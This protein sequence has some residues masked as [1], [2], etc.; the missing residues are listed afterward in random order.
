MDDHRP[1]TQ[2]T[3]W[4]LRVTDRR[5]LLLFGDF[6]ISIIS[7]VIAIS[8][9]A[10]AEAEA[11]SF[12]EFVSARLE[13]WFFLLPVIWLILLVDS[14]DP[15]RSTNIKG[16]IQSI[17]GA[18][19]IGAVMYM[20]VYFTSSAS[21]PRRGVAIFLLSSAVLTLLWRYV[22]IG[23]FS[24]PR[25]LH[26]VLLVGGGETGQALLRVL[27]DIQP[28]PYYLVGIIDDD[29]DK[30]GTEIYSYPVLGG[31]DCLLDTIEKEN[32][33]DLI[34]AISGKMIS[35]T[36]QRLLEAQEHGVQIT[37]MPVAYEDLLDRVPVQYLE[38]DWILRAFVDEARRGVFYELGKRIL[39]IIGGLV[40]VI[41]LALIT[42]FIALAILFESGRPV[43]FEQTRVGRGGVPF[44]ILKFRSMI[45]DQ[46][47]EEEAAFATEDQDRI[48]RLGRFLRKT[49]LDEWPQFI[50]V[51]RGDMSLVGPR[52]ERPEFVQ[53]FETQIPFY[54]ARF[55]VKPGIAGWAQV[56]FDYAASVREIIMKLEYDLYYI[57]HRN[58][59]LDIVIMLRTFA[60]VIGLRG[61]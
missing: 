56:H 12:F 26:R 29:M 52:P 39:D 28:K 1:K 5:A 23:V 38:A 54:R 41:I 25:F 7:L 10:S 50:N 60:T 9:W 32:V 4:R 58:I 43:V 16:S 37:R 30:I 48:T 40:G 34:V 57:K 22:Y 6:V 61:E 47:R 35:E 11:R 36:F 2:P 17:A 27:R 18:A 24:T 31:S 44:T 14:Y 3:G 8:L 59:W 49:H 20:T 42:P 33:S 45:Q 13:F 46:K 55:L 53:A 15:R 51:L 21:L 19:G